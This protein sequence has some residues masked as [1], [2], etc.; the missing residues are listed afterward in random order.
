MVV[1]ENNGFRNVHALGTIFRNNVHVEPQVVLT[2]TSCPSVLKISVPDKILIALHD[3]L[4]PIHVIPQFHP[5]LF[6]EEPILIR[7][8]TFIQAVPP[9]SECDENLT[10]RPPFHYGFIVVSDFRSDTVFREEKPSTSVRSPHMSMP[11]SYI[12]AET[13]P[14]HISMHARNS[15]VQCQS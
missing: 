14:R 4:L 10:G 6:R 9:L 15:A 7:T 8:K 3:C 13:I 11:L 5:Q 1:N 2:P 12:K